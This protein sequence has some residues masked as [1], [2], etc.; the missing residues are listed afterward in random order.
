M[1]SRE[2]KDVSIP[3]LQLGMCAL[4][5]LVYTPG[6]STMPVLFNVYE[7]KVFSRPSGPIKELGRI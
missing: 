7:E 2:T 1:E 6:P 5:S 3:M 4:G